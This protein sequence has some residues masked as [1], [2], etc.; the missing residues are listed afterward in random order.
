MPGAVR[1][2]SR[3]ITFLAVVLTALAIGGLYF[4]N[5]NVLI[6]F[7]AAL[8]VLMVSGSAIASVNGMK[9]SF[10]MY[11]LGGN[12]GMKFVDSISR[13][14]RRF[15]TFLSDWGLAISFGL[16]SF[17]MFR[18]QVSKKTILFGIASVLAIL[19][20]VYPYLSVVISFINIPQLTAEAASAGSTAAPGAYLL[21]YLLIAAGVIGGLSA[22]GM[23]VIFYGGG[24]ILY[25]ILL[26]MAEYL[27]SKPN[28]SGLS[29][30]IPGVA[31]LIPGLTLPLV[32]GV[33]SLFTILVVHEF[34]H[35]ALARIA[36]VKLKS[37]GVV[38]FGIIP[39]G[40]FVE[41]DEKAIRRLGK[42]DRDRIFA[43]G[44]SANMLVSLAFFVATVL[45]MYLVLPAVGTGGVRV[46]EVLPNNTAYGVISPNTVIL[47][48]NGAAITN[49][50]DLARAE[51]SYAPGSYVNVTTSAG[52]YRLMPSSE[53]KLGVIVVPAVATAAFQSANFVYS[54]VVLLFALN[55]FVAIFNLLPIP[56]FDGWRIYDDK[57]KNKKALKFAAALLIAAIL[58]NVL[59]WFWTL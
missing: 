18:R 5:G 10:G 1:A 20:F 44:I 37:I 8:A 57:V 2:H 51:A 4:V 3:A 58:V 53:G 43:A 56:G 23:L 28:T 35:G 11:M 49:N 7:A 22:F 36:R 45:M 50:Y 16:L 32:A 14:N 59:P 46:T 12:G 9:S 41:P 19:I 34:S 25:G 24:T 40:A 27:S 17:A 29:S 54:V 33:I 55:F 13:K 30:Q 21:Y 38:L 6:R 31:P 48:W 26:F 15:W 39:I 42:R 52:S 47:G